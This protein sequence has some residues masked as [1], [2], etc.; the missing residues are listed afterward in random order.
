MLCFE[1]FPCKSNDLKILP[2]RSNGIKILRGIRGEGY[3]PLF[4]IGPL[5]EELPAAS[6]QL[7]AKTKTTAFRRKA[8]SEWRKALC[9]QDFTCKSNG[10]K[11]LRGR[12][13]GIKILHGI[14]GRGC[15]LRS[16]TRFTGM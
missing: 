6:L 16:R 12:S 11:N 13:N 5:P 7:P 1:N 10:L 4:A 9:P 2:R 8:K 3:E 15:H 14:W